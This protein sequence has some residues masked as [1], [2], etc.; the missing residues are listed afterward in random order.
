MLFLIVLQFHGIS[1]FLIRISSIS[2]EIQGFRSKYY[3][4]R[5]K[6]QVF[7]LKYQVFRKYVTIIF[8]I[9]FSV[10][11]STV[12]YSVILMNCALIPVITKNIYIVLDYEFLFFYIFI[13]FQKLWLDSKPLQTF[14]MR[15]FFDKRSYFLLF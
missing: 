10:I 14:L 3:V 12:D 1:K 4:F 8:L 9:A 11:V 6:Y 7:R 2:M 15:S 5:L 13:T